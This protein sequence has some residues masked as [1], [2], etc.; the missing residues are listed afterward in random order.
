MPAG[1][2]PDRMEAR[3]EGTE[4]RDQADFQRMNFE[5]LLHRNLPAGRFPLAGTTIR[6][7][8]KRCAY[9]THRPPYFSGLTDRRSGL[10]AVASGGTP[11][12]SADCGRPHRL[13]GGRAGTDAGRAEREAVPWPP[14]RFFKTHYTLSSADS[15]QSPPRRVTRNH[16]GGIRNRIKVLPGLGRRR[17]RRFSIRSA[18]KWC[19]RQAICEHYTKTARSGIWRTSPR[20]A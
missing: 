8:G 4:R 10:A 15:D 6:L 7:I 16:P 5:D 9:L 2:Y 3:S 13:G 12:S 17:V 14:F 11:R 19:S 20:P 18:P 1:V